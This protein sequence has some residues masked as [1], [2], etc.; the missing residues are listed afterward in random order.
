MIEIMIARH[1]EKIQSTTDIFANDPLSEQGIQQALG[2]YTVV[3]IFILQ[4]L[5]L[6]H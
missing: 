4:S 5:F 2:L 6:A 1:A 3:K